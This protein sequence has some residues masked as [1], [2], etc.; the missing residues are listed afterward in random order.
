MKKD[1]GAEMEGTGL[2]DNL[3]AKLESVDPKT[4]V[5]VFRKPEEEPLKKV[6]IVRHLLEPMGKDGVYV[7]LNESSGYLHRLFTQGLTRPAKLSFIDFNPPAQRIPAGPQ[8]TLYVSAKTNLT[9]FSILLNKAIESDSYHFLFL[10]SVMALIMGKPPNEGER[11][12]KYLVEKIGLFELIGIFAVE[13]E[14]PSKILIA[15][16]NSKSM[17]VTE[18]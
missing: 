16:A 12:L 13:P 2:F 14:F 9:E 18:L 4:L 10:D 17:T 6:R 15:S 5:L 3:E 1:K 11:F 7:A 8:S